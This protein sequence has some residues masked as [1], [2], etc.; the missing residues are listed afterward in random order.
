MLALTRMH[1]DNKPQTR[2]ETLTQQPYVCASAEIIVKLDQQCVCKLASVCACRYAEPVVREVLDPDGSL[3]QGRV[4]YRQH[5]L[6]R[7]VPTSS[8]HH[9]SSTSHGSTHGSGH[10]SVQCVKDLSLLG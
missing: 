5:T 9:D 6:I 1:I 8:S 2:I 10:T 3:F 7:R 4:L